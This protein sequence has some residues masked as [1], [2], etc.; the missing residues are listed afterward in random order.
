MFR[1]ETILTGID[2]FDEASY[3]SMRN[4]SHGGGAEA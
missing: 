4:F 2:I 1:H 3:S